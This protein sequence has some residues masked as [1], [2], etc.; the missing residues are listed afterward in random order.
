M[1]GENLDGPSM[2]GRNGN[3]SFA[4]D[5]GL[6]PHGSSY[7]CHGTCQHVSNAYSP[8]ISPSALPGM[9]APEEIG[10]SRA[11]SASPHLSQ[12]NFLPQNQTE[13]YAA[14]Y[15]GSEM[16]TL[17]SAGGTA[18]PDMSRFNLPSFS[19]IHNPSRS[20]TST[21][22]RTVCYYF[23]VP[24]TLSDTH[25]LEHVS[26]VLSRVLPPIRQVV[27]HIAIAAPTTR[28]SRGAEKGKLRADNTSENIEVRHIYTVS[29][30]K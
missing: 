27:S 18:P 29:S 6:H 21:S 14:S 22:H 20:S 2:G 4:Q 11:R 12:F 8:S 10:Q 25:S 26:R 15:P 1:Y 3:P 24:H 13:V 5:F 19:H 23:A 9:L 16:D 17:E 7:P 30:L 28:R